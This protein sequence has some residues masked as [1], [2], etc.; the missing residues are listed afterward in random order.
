MPSVLSV[1][2]TIT[3]LHA[4]RPWL[5]CS[6]CGTQ[7]PFRSSDNIRV[8]ANGKRLDIWLIYRCITCDNSWNRPI[9]ER[10]PINAID[11]T[12]LQRLMSNDRGTARHLAFDLVS[13]RRQ[14]A[15]IEEFS[16]LA[17]SKTILCPSANASTLE[18]TCAPQ[19]SS[20][21]LDR[22][23]ATELC[24][25]RRQVHNMTKA[26]HILITANKKRPLRQA[27]QDGTQIRIA[28]SAV[29]NAGALIS[30]AVGK[31]H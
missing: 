22:L 21:R 29:D 24:L 25:S 18:I 13:L 20:I 11:P 6:H 8:N 5:H 26:G 12:Q 9:I 1:R 7:K 23:L 3:P 10:K 15:K 28:L 4:P 16:D 2:W 30:A 17:I 14:V 27:V 19:K 31:N